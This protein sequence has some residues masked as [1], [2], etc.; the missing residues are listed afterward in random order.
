VGDDGGPGAKG[1]KAVGIRS[2]G[3]GI[4]LCI[5]V[6]SIKPEQG[7]FHSIPQ[8]TRNTGKGGGGGVRNRKAQN[9]GVGAA[10]GT[11]GSQHVSESQFLVLV[12]IS[13]NMYICIYIHMYNVGERTH[14]C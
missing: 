1:A 9:D 4:I 3:D 11:N 8:G 10:V 14:P 6:V 2:D 12:G 13:I 5:V 7:Q